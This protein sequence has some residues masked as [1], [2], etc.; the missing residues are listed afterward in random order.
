MTDTHIDAF[1]DGAFVGCMMFLS[2]M[3]P[4]LIAYLRYHRN[5]R[6][7]A[8]L[9]LLLGW[10]FFGWVMAFVWALTSQQEELRHGHERR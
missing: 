7:I 6:A 9:N 4:A 8:A 2:Y 3:L 10:T 5:W 1:I